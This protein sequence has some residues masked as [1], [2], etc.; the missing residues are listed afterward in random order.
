MPTA[1]PVLPTLRA[2]VFAAVCL[3]LGAGAHTL[4]THAPISAWAL[5]IG[6]VAAFGPARVAAARGERGLV[7]ILQF[8]GGLQ[9]VLHLLFWYAQQVQAASAPGAM[10]GMA[11]KSGAGPLDMSGGMLLGHALAALAC[12]WWMRCGEAAVHGIARRALARL[13]VIVRVVAACVIPPADR[14]TGGACSAPRVAAVLGSQWLRGTLARRGPPPSSRGRHTRS[15]LRA[16]PA[17]RRRT[18]P[19]GLVH[20][21]S[22]TV[23]HGVRSLVH[24]LDV[25]RDVGYLVPA[26]WLMWKPRSPLALDA[27]LVGE[28]EARPA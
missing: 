6:A 1:G 13:R 7:P 17:H 21:G 16:T 22:F 11:G 9:I 12:A 28:P 20:Q 25:L 14:V 23:R 5:A 27:C 10:A 24:A 18:R 2:A 26:A 4:M 19:R 3:G 15:S 8:M